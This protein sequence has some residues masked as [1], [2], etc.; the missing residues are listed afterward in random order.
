MGELLALRPRGG[1]GGEW[2]EG[3]A[4]SVT[5]MR[6]PPETNESTQSLVELIE[7]LHQAASEAAAQGFPQMARTLDACGFSF[8]NELADDRGNERDLVERAR[9]CLA[10]WSAMRGW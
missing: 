7:S 2:E 10:M 4:R 1:G 8:A 3:G 5:T 9:K 6:R